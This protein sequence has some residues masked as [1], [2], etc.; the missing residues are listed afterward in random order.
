MMTYEALRKQY[1]QFIYHGFEVTEEPGKVCITYDLKFPGSLPLR[2]HGKFPVTK[3]TWE[4]MRSFC[5]W[6]F[7]WGW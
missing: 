3:K 1:P 2:L 4:K 7:P 5:I 6:S